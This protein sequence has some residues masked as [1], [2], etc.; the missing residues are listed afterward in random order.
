VGILLTKI[1]F[2]YYIEGSFL[3]FTYFFGVFIAILGI[4]LFSAGIKTT[5][6]KVSIC[7]A[8]YHIND[9]SSGECKKCNLPLKK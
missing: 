9:V 4:A 1:T 3:N 5:A 2:F 8:C 6:T 7:P